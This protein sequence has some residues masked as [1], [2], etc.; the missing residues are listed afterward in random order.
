MDISIIIPTKNEED[1]I[2]RLLDSLKDQ[3][4][5]NFEVIIIDNHS[6]DKT[7]KIAAKFTDK[8]F[9][10]G[11]ER[12]VQK[13]LGAKI[14]RG[15]FLLFLDA[16][17]ML[18][19]G[20][21]KIFFETVKKTGN[22]ALVIPEEIPGNDF[23]S[24][25]RNFEKSLYF[26]DRLI[27]APRFIKKSVFLKIGGYNPNLISG[28]DWDLYERLGRVTTK[29]SHAKVSILHL[30]SPLSLIKTIKKKFYYGQHIQKYFLKHPKSSIYQF[31]PIRKAYLKNYRA[32]FSKPDLAFGL[33]ILK[34]VESIAGGT[35]FIVGLFKP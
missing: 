23:F 14:A 13:N 31:N 28:E 4:F 22:D 27:E 15:D 30:E 20:S 24:R 7:V 1:N 6:K 35:G 12:S 29:I 19:K 21:I 3:T 8:I 17:M 25:C 9:K 34:T 2:A 18:K 32:L 33:A 26:K 16:D 11:P 10:K 5:K